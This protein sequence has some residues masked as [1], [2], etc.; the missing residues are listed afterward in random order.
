MA[1]R[2]KNPERGRR[3]DSPHFNRYRSMKARC[4]SKKHE[5]YKDYGARGIRVCQEWLDDFWAYH[6]YMNSLEGYEKG[7]TGDRINN[8][9]HYEPGNMRWA[10]KSQ[11]ASNRRKRKRN[12]K[13][14]YE[15]KRYGGWVVKLFVAG[16]QR[17]FGYYQ[18]KTAAKKV[19]DFA[20]DLIVNSGY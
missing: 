8:D 9:G 5:R 10:T 14:Y 12:V 6:D 7:L 3:K 2:L 1:P 17:Y 11:Q 20:R 18:T 4:Y 13:G 15:D 19:A 16:K